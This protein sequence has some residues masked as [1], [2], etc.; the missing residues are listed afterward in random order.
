MNFRAAQAL[1]RPVRGLPGKAFKP[2]YYNRS[3]ASKACHRPVSAIKKPGLEFKGR[4]VEGAGG[5]KGTAVVADVTLLKLSTGQLRDHF[6]Q[7]L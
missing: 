7:S 5:G 1:F 2:S 4:T 6:P 3:K